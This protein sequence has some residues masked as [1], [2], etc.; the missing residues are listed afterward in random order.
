MHC[1]LFS[2]RIQRSGVV[3][4]VVVVEKMFWSAAEQKYVEEQPSLVSLLA[5]F[6]FECVVI[7]LFTIFSSSVRTD[8][9]VSH[10]TIAF[11]PG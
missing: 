7:S 10:V 2:Q 6:H 3:L 8:K 9:S 11:F 5:N 4:E 1:R